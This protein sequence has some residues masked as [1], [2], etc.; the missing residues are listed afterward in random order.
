M[1]NADA[2]MGPVTQFGGG[3]SSML[4]I[5][6]G[7][8]VDVH[9]ALKPLGGGQVIQA[10]RVEKRATL[11]AYLRVSGIVSALGEGGTGQFT[12]GSLT[13]DHAAAVIL[14]KGAS[15]VNGAS[16]V[17]LAPPTNLSMTAGSNPVLKAST[18][19][20]KSFRNAS[21]ET[22]TSG[23]VALL[24]SASGQ[25]SLNGQLVKFRP[26]DVQP[27]GTMLSNGQYVVA[28]GSV[29]ANGML[30][31]TLVKL[32]DGKSEPEAELKGSIGN[33]NSTNNTFLIRDVLVTLVATTKLE[34]C[35][36]SGLRDGLF[37][38]MQGSLDLTGVTAKKV[39]CKDEPSGAVIERK[40]VAS[41]VDLVGSTFTLIASGRAP[42]KVVWTT[43]TFFRS[44]TPQTLSGK[45][46]EAEGTLVDGDLIA[47]KIKIED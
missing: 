34:H 23:F 6:A 32:R 15:L 9:G 10:T 29:D 40:G 2:S 45:T 1:V 4:D 42:V 27:A 21:A 8:S 30:I 12:L 19:R 20:V 16:V 46:V 3:Y 11:P 13:V 17:V 38:E 41:G 24:D 36:A 39:A 5:Q 7:H 28:R 18:V 25:F 47:T 37:V 31:A 26:V 22:F 35:P 33:F 43:L 44:V 14:P